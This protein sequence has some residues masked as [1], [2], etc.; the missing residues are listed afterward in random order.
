MAMD[1][2]EMRFN[3]LLNDI[4]QNLSKENLESLKFLCKPSI[5]KKKLESITSGNQLFQVLEELDQ[6]SSKYPDELFVLLGNIKRP[7]LQNKLSA[8]QQGNGHLQHPVCEVGGITERLNVA[9]NV[10]CDGV[11]KD[12][13]MV[14]RTLGH[15]EALLQQIEYKY[16]FNMREQI[17][18]ALIEWQKTKG[19]EATEDNLVK[20]LRRCNL[21]LVADTVEEA[22]SKID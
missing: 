9:F 17:R 22:V 12:W 4:S 2:A 8:F 13:R 5:G 6:L 15:K 7:D 10:I 18:Q 21:N 16:P 19:K 3:V 20:V 14:A 11:G 1:Q